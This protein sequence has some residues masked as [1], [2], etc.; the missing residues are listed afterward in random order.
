MYFVT[1][2]ILQDVTM[3]TEFDENLPTIGALT[4]WSLMEKLNRVVRFINCRCHD[5]NQAVKLEKKPRPTLFT[6]VRWIITVEIN[7]SSGVY[8]N[9]NTVDF[10]E[11]LS[12]GFG[13]RAPTVYKR[14]STP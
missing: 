5:R 3:C 6:R 7:N 13:G 11:T 12:R 8:I 9:E 1:T 14:R 2:F 4:C 10:F